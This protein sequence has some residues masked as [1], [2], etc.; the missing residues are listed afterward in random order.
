MNLRETACT[1]LLSYA[2]PYQLT[3]D[4]GVSEYGVELHSCYLGQ[5]LAG[6]IATSH[7]AVVAGQPSRVFCAPSDEPEVPV[8]DRRRDCLVHHLDQLRVLVAEATGGAVVVDVTERALARMDE[9]GPIN[10]G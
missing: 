1:T 7:L 5:R 8:G 10:R 4:T 6:Y 9:T 2:G 3:L